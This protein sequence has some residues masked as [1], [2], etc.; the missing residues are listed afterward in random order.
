M[1][2]SEQA[3]CYHRLMK[4][5]F[6]VLPSAEHRAHIRR[7][8]RSTLTGCAIRGY[9]A[10]RQ[11]EHSLRAAAAPVELRTDRSGKKPRK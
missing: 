2:G 6:F 7:F 9:I 8:Q 5:P 10:W 4:N 1:S 11:L 3:S